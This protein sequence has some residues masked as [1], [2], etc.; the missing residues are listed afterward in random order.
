MPY[1]HLSSPFFFSFFPLSCLFLPPP[2]PHQQA[3][4]DVRTA[5]RWISFMWH[6]RSATAKPSDDVTRCSFPIWY[7]T[8]HLQTGNYWERSVTK[9]MCMILV[10]AWLKSLNW[11]SWMWPSKRQDQLA[12]L[13]GCYCPVTKLCRV[14]IGIK[15]KEERIRKSKQG[16]P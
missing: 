7:F 13:S 1:L 15:W 2:P 14:S 10:K 11:A 3:M 16:I 4:Q 9:N 8:C 6:M 12:V 5:V